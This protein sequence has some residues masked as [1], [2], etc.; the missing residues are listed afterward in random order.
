YLRDLLI[1]FTVVNLLPDLESL[2]RAT[3]ALIAAGCFL[4]TAALIQAHTGFR[5]GGLANTETSQISGPLMGVRLAG[6]VPDS[7]FFAQILVPLVPLALYRA[8]GEQRLLFRLAG[9]L[10]F[11]LLVGTIVLTF[12]RGGLLGLLL[13]IAFAMALQIRHP[14][15][16][17]PLLIVL[18]LGVL[19]TPHSYWDRL[20]GIVPLDIA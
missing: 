13:V 12:S 11:V 19:F 20:A 2:R 16:L 15:R 3:W 5:F 17:A 14:A 7:N 6:P 10:A 1:A 8:W 9:L 18:A 4:A